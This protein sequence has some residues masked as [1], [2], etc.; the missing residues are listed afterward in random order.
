MVQEVFLALVTH[1]SSFE[2]Q[3]SDATFRGWLWTITQNKI[4]DLHRRGAGRAVAAGGTDAQQR[5]LEVPEPQTSGSLDSGSRHP[6]TLLAQALECIRSEFEACSWQAFW[7]VVVEGKAPVELAATL[8]I[9]VNAV[10]IAR[11]RILR[12]FVKSCVTRPVSPRAWWR[13][14]STPSKE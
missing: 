3:R 13:R 7:G 5:L 11:S 8:G 12:G 10:Y 9:S 2:H 4:R 1:L 14:L 6:S